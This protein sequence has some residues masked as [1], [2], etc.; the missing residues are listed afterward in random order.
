MGDVLRRARMMTCGWFVT[1]N[2]IISTSTKCL[3]T[4]G[5][6]VSVSLWANRGLSS[7]RPGLGGERSVWVVV[8]ILRPEDDLRSWEWTGLAQWAFLPRPPGRPCGR[9]WWAPVWLNG[10]RWPPVWLHGRSRAWA[11]WSTRWTTAKRRKK[12]NIQM[13]NLLRKRMKIKDLCWVCCSQVTPAELHCKAPQ[14]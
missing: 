11:S 9:P 13:S 4:H 3:L 14:K 7:F 10:T 5:T 1:L 2:T 8:R 6:E 12:R